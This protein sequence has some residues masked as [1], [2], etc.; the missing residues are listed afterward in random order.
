MRDEA[1]RFANTYHRRLR[2]RARLRSALDAIDGVGPAR[3]RALLRELGSVRRVRE[4]SEE[5][6]MRVPGVSRALA[7]RIREALGKS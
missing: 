7:S 4:A 6:L 2:A 1:H 5:E 3:R